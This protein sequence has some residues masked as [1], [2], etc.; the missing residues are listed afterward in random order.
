M[1]KF[2]CFLIAIMI[3]FLLMP[4][5]IRFMLKYNVLDR[6]G[7]RKIHIGTKVNMGGIVIFLGFMASYIIAI[8]SLI[9]YEEL[10]LVL[11]FAL[12]L[13]IIVVI[14]VRDDIKSLSPK[15]KLVVE[16]IIG[17]FICKI[18]I[19][20]DNFYGLFGVNE[21]PTWISYSF[22]IFFFI[23]VAN[24]YN[25][26]DGV[27]GQSGVQ[28]LI[29]IIPLLLFFL[30]IVPDHGYKVGFGNAQFWSVITISLSGAIIAYLYYNWYP[31][32]VF[33][34]D[35]GSIFI[36]LML[37][38]IMIVA[39]KYN[40]ELGSNAKIF[41]HEIKSKIGVVVMMFYMPLVD[42]LRV[43]VC[44]AMKKKSPFSPDRSHIHHFILRTGGTHQRCVFTTL[45]Y[46]VLYS[47]IG[48]ILS[49]FLTDLY[50]IMFM[51]LAFPFF[52]ISLC[53]VIKFRMNKMKKIRL[54]QN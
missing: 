15:V 6:S 49:L 18:G 2:Y 12:L 39:I 33:M 3:V 20:I 5:F 38:C 21:L 14:G 40:G 17:M 51:V 11:S 43:F 28:A 45:I 46:S 42:T 30:F 10:D 54:C 37:A 34:G 9:A 47:S 27:D 24:A 29:T 26:I 52:V 53:K 31:S 1:I 41:G 7:G 48:I 22:S 16:I 4:I 19:R 25:L 44:R 23:V 36:G 8:P 50:F 35:T 13:C 32:K